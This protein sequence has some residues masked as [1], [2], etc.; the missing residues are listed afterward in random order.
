MKLTREINTSIRDFFALHG[1]SEVPVLDGLFNG[2]AGNTI[3]HQHFQ[4][5][6]R[7]V[8]P[9][10]FFHVFQAIGAAAQIEQCQHGSFLFIVF[11]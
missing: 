11:A 4:F 3:Y 2:W 7:R 5:F 10:N 8:K 6:T 9:E 1:I